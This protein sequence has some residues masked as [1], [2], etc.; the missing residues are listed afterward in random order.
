MADCVVFLS[1]SVAAELSR[2][3]RQYRVSEHPALVVTNPSQ[4]RRPGGRMVLFVGRI[5]PYKGVDLLLEAWASRNFGGA[6]LVIAGEGRIPSAVALPSVRVINRWL[7]ER[8]IE[9]LIASAALVV[10]PYREASQSG[11]VPIAKALGVPV[12]ATPVGGLPEQFINDVEGVLARDT[13]I[14]GLADAIEGALTRTWLNTPNLS[15]NEVFI[16]S[17]LS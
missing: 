9:E 1:G 5:R 8:E 16:R 14:A 4:R 11:I 13:S 10:L 15:A 12:V 6:E 17:I 2:F 3:A 7:S